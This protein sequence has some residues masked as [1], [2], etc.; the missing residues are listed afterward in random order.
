[1]SFHLNVAQ[2]GDALELLQSLPAIQAG[3]ILADPAYHFETWSAKGQSR[4]PSR[5]YTGR[6]HGAAGVRVRRR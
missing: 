4:S 5:H 6:D 1:M 3:A 2:Q